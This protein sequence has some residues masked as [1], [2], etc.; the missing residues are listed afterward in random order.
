MADKWGA[1]APG[2]F[3]PL[4]ARVA[5]SPKFHSV[6]TSPDKRPPQD[7]PDIPRPVIPAAA[8]D[9]DF[10]DTPLHDLQ[11]SIVGGAM[12]LSGDSQ[13]LKEKLDNMT[14]GS[15]QAVLKDVR[16]MMDLKKIPF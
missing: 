6:F 4:T 13:D 5:A 7:W 12:A 14:V 3:P 15:G 16:G 8:A 10:A 11:R 1:V 9:F 2:K